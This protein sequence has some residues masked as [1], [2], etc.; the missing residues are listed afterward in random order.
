MRTPP[1][2]SRR[3]ISLTAA[4][5][6]AGLGA[7]VPLAPAEAAGSTLTVNVAQPIRPVTHVAAGG[8]KG[9]ASNSWPNDSTLLPLT[10]NSLTQPAPG[11][12][13]RPNGQ[14]PG[15]DSLLVAPQATRVGAG[16]YIRMPDVYP[17]FPYQWVNWNDWL[18][19]VDTM[20]R[21]RLNATSVTNIVGWELWNEP[22]WTW[23]TGAAGSFNDGWVRTFRAV[24]ALD[25]TTPIVGPSTA[26]YSRSWMSSFLTNA[27]A[28]GTLPDIICW[29]ELGGP[30]NIAANIADYRSLESTG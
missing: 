27:K 2:T 7:F 11:V 25:T 8:L 29:H 30:G 4:L 17:N 5:L 1:T 16:E 21:A 14:P 13:Q 20:V 15:G 19:K 9:R 28:T 10:V 23:N 6:A 3:A 26:Y 24:R 22:D 18:A 12:G